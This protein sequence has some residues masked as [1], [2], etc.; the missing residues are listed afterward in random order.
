MEIKKVMND[1]RTLGYFD[2]VDKTRLVADASPF[3]LGA[4]LIQFIGSLPRNISYA[5]EALSET[6]QRNSQTEKEAL[7]LVWECERFY[8]YLCGIQLLFNMLFSQ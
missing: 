6:E 3:E 4:V 5:S 8:I 1:V 7:A 2:P